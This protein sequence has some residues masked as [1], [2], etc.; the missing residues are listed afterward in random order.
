[1]QACM[2]NFN[3]G[4]MNACECSFVSAMPQRVVEES[5]SKAPKLSSMFAMLDV[6]QDGTVSLDEFMQMLLGRSTEHTQ[7]ISA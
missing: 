4:S 7:Q 1:M 3:G 6:N 2:L 5:G